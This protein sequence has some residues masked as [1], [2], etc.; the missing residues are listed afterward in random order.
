MKIGLCNGSLLESGT[1]KLFP[2]S[3]ERLKMKW[4]FK[5]TR[6]DSQ[7]LLPPTH[8]KYRCFEPI[9]A[10]TVPSKSL[11][12][13]STVTEHRQS[14]GGRRWR[15]YSQHTVQAACD[16]GMTQTNQPNNQLRALIFSENLTVVQLLK[17]FVVLFEHSCEVLRAVTIKNTI[18]WDLRSSGILSS[19][20]W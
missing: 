8:A 16:C 12:L 1:D 3:L 2:S 6:E 10:V 14:E 15:P 19:V 20:W 9:S 7:P 5:K 11:S 17:K 4:S 13:L 18:F